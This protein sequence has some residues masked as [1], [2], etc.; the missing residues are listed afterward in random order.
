M[1]RPHSRR[2]VESYCRRKQFNP[3]D[4]AQIISMFAERGY[5]NDAAFAKAWIENRRLTKPI[6]TR[7]L[8]LELKQKGIPDDLIAQSLAES[9][10]NEQTA[11]QTLITKKRRLSRFK[12]DDK[13]LTQYLLRQGFGF[14]EIRRGLTK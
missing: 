2:E 6:S 3:D 12:N 10:Y 7:I 11:L 5:I 1:L 13:K 9:P 8:R 14:D 4:C